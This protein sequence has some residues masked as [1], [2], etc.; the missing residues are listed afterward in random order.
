MHRSFLIVLLL[1]L[2]GISNFTQNTGAKMFT[3]QAR[4]SLSE[5][6]NPSDVKITVNMIKRLP[7][8]WEF[9][10]VSHN[11]G[12]RSVFVMSDAV[13][14]DGSPGAYL[15]ISPK[16]N[17]LLDLGIRLFALPSYCTLSS[18]T[19]V[20]LRRLDP[21]ASFKEVITIKLPLRETEPPYENPLN[22]SPIDWSK[23]KY[24]RASV[25]ILPDEEGVQDFLKHKEGIGPY[26]SGQE[27]IERGL[28]RGKRLLELQSVSFSERVEINVQ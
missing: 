8:R 22:K 23:V 11:I 14:V 9:E 13:R 16:D 5:T 10:V 21:S 27:S 20:T 19:H 6:A 18:A 24:I 2:F 15:S 3:A 17:E 28:F 25:G 12:D 4:T 7:D 1:I 26:A